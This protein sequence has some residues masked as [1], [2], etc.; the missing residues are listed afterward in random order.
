MWPFTIC[1]PGKFGTPRERRHLANASSSSWCITSPWPV[2]ELSLGAR[3]RQA[4][5]A[6]RTVG[7]RSSI[8]EGI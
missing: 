5:Y 7:N 2:S 8:D 1:G 6:A 3:L 4:R